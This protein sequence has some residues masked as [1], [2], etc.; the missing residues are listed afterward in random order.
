MEVS[1]QLSWFSQ[2]DP[3]ASLDAM[4]QGK[5]FSAAS[6]R[7]LTI[8]PIAHHYTGRAILACNKRKLNSINLT[9]YNVTKIHICLR[10]IK[11]YLNMK[12]NTVEPY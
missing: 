12:I 5:I 8:Q 1:G 10:G 2:V 4:E 9:K 6:S 7:T 11:L 3:R